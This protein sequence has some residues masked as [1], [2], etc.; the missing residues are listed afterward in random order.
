MK[1]IRYSYKL[2]CNRLINKAD[3]ISLAIIYLCLKRKL[4]SRFLKSKKKVF[5]FSINGNT[6]EL[7]VQDCCPLLRKKDQEK[8]T[9]PFSAVI[10]VIKPR[11]YHSLFLN[12]LVV[13]DDYTQLPDSSPQI[14]R[15]QSWNTGAVSSHHTLSQLKQC[16]SFVLS[17][18][19]RQ[20]H[21][22]SRVQTTQ[23]NL[24]L[25]FKPSPI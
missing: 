1:H 2:F 14:D 4:W 13:L 19:L 11:Y 16:P 25:W 17:L 7:M 24:L 6:S 12:G 18:P 22:S 9:W 15:V 20:T 3:I 21:R 10:W 5:L 8:C 23:N